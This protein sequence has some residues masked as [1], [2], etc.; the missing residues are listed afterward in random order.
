MPAAGAKRYLIRLHPAQISRFNLF[1]FG[2]FCRSVFTSQRFPHP[3]NQ[4]GVFDGVADEIIFVIPQ[5][6][7][8]FLACICPFPCL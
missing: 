7:Q 8:A 3:Q 2:G 5:N 6:C 4:F 1:W